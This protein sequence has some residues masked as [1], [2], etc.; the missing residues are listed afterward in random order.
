M[1]I[2]T[3]YRHG[4]YILTDTYLRCFSNARTIPAWMIPT[5]NATI[6]KQSEEDVKK[7]GYLYFIQV[8]V[9]EMSK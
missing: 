1:P 6:T 8:Q 2:W 4:V 7:S 3:K 9:K 5:E